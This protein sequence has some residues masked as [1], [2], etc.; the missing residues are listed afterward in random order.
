MAMKEDVQL[1]L[2]IKFG[3]ETMATKLNRKDP[4]KSIAQLGLKNNPAAEFRVDIDAQ[5]KIKTSWQPKMQYPLAVTSFSKKSCHSI[6]KPFVRAILPK[7]GFNRNIIYGS[8]R[9]GSFQMAH[10]YNEQGIWL[11]NIL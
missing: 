11:S 6:V 8:Y 5:N 4:T 1:D 10:L 2:S 7:R 3:N 9:Y